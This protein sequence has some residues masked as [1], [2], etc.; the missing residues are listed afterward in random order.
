M[1][2]AVGG[3]ASSG[4][5]R[6]PE[7][8]VHR[9]LP[10]GA[11]EVPV[12]VGKISRMGFGAP[13]GEDISVRF[14]V[15]RGRPRLW[16]ACA[17]M[18]AGKRPAPCRGSFRALVK[19]REGGERCVFSHASRGEGWTEAVVE[20]SPY[21]GRE[22]ELILQSGAGGP[23]AADLSYW[24]TPIVISGGS[25]RPNV[26]LISIDSL[27]ADHLKCCGYTRTTSPTL[28]SLA[29][30]GCL[31]RKAIAQSSWTLPS[32]TSIF[33]S[34]YLSSHGV[35]SPHDALTLDA[36]TLSEGLRDA[37]YLTGAVIA[38]GPLLPMYGLNQGFDY[39]DATCFTDKFDDVRNHCTHARALEWLDRCGDAPFFL[40][41]HYWDV[42]HSYIP[43]P[44]YDEMFDPG[45]D[46][47]VDGRHILKLIPADL[48]R[49]DLEHL[50]ALYDGE[51]AHTDRYIG[52]LLQELRSRGMSHNT[53]L[54]V[55]SDHGDE[56]LDHGATG[57][58]HTVYQELIHVPLIWVDPEARHRPEPVDYTVQTIDIAPSILD[59]LGLP[60]PPSMEGTSL[61]GYTRGL[62][63]R[64]R[65]AFSEA[66]TS[67]HRYAVLTESAKLVASA[68]RQ[69]RGYNLAADPSE[70]NPLAPDRLP[71]GAQLDRALKA[72]FDSPGRT[73][74]TLE[75][76]VAGGQ[77]RGD[78]QVSLM[79]LWMVG[80]E[81]FGLEPSDTLE[82]AHDSTR[83]T[84]A[85]DC[86]PG[87]VDGVSLR[88]FSEE[89]A[90][91]VEP[92][93]RHRPVRPNE[94]TL[95]A[96]SRPHEGV[97][98]KVRADD[99]VLEGAPEQFSPTPAGRPGVYVWVVKEGL[100]PT[101]PIELEKEF[102][103]QLRALGYLN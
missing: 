79:S 77:A 95:G 45:Y 31:F 15:P 40:F 26:L 99:P 73:R 44:P 29:A 56:L 65:P 4:C 33:T 52:S 38:G 67:D 76:R 92:T 81:S 28:D 80:V 1:L 39:Y 102:Q 43:P 86:P 7:K 103:E 78:L 20:L 60:I 46:G 53:L 87:D 8:T 71:Q 47:R 90:V 83:V 32:H 17:A 85:L 94:V 62:Q 13:A 97:P 70:Q 59:R 37:G 11:R 57:H 74:V 88:L 21:A 82:V 101:V 61:L 50:V 22:V 54:V 68:Y 48:P 19:T 23:A 41:V 98:L 30:A 6:A 14:S 2:L 3:L 49:R 9:L 96:D 89:T 5:T 16:L 27:R 66:A 63:Q 18:T 36:K 12:E 34:L 51:I 72:Y 64:A 55:T 93:F 58:G 84:L 25:R 42:H 100:A 24:A 69:F 75:L 35:N 10:A 91:W